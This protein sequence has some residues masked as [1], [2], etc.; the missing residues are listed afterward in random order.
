MPVFVTNPP[1]PDDSARWAIYTFEATVVAVVVGV[2]GTVAGIWLLCLTLLKPRLGVTLWERHRELDFTPVSCQS[3]APNRP[4]TF[5]PELQVNNDGKAAAKSGYYITLWLPKAFTFDHGSLTANGWS[6]FT[7]KESFKSAPSQV[8]WK[9]ERFVPEPLFVG[10]SVRVP[11][12]TI[13]SEIGEA[14]LQMRWRVSC[15]AG[16]VPPT[17][18]EPGR[19]KFGVRLP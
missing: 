2:G 19:L 1:P 18:L 13:N 12:F 16:Q 5:V 8:Y 11:S 15:E 17:G 10:H 7:M 14:S 3:N 9:I 6:F 4:M